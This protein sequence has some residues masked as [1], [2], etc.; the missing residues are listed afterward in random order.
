VIAV[1]GIGDGHG[2]QKGLFKKAPPEELPV[3]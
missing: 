1:N 3:I 2:K